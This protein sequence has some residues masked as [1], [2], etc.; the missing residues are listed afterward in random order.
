LT[1][2]IA[3]ILRERIA[4]LRVSQIHVANDAGM[5]KSQLSAFLGG[6]KQIDI[7]QFES[8]CESL[9]LDWIEVLKQAEDASSLRRLDRRAAKREEQ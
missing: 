8:V 9:G 3:A 5:S 4:R 7:E 2:E 1:Q 6:Q